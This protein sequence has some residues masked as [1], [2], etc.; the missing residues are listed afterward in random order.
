VSA[1]PDGPGL[2]A[3]FSTFLREHVLL[4]LLPVVLFYGFLFWLAYKQAV[5]PTSPFIYRF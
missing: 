4:W 1:R 2:W 3:E 5:V